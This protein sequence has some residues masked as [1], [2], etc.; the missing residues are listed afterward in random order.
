[1]FET[2]SIIIPIYNEDRTLER[3]IRAVERAP[4]FDLKKEIVL[5]D[6]FSTDK[7]RK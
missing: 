4:I 7:S 5:V 6:D 2:L 3:I 1:M